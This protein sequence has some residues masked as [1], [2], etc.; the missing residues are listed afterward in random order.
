VNLNSYEAKVIG[1]EKYK[2]I[3]KECNLFTKKWTISRYKEFKKM[4]KNE[5]DKHKKLFSKKYKRNKE[6]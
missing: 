5:M 1:K 2:S 4:I 3:A 6:K